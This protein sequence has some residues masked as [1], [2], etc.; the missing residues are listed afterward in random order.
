[1]HDAQWATLKSLHDNDTLP[2]FWIFSGDKGCGKSYFAQ[3]WI[4]YWVRCHDIGCDPR[5]CIVQ[6]DKEIVIDDIV[7]LRRFLSAKHEGK[8]F[9]LIDNANQMNRFVQNALLKIFE[10]NYEDT[11]IILI[12]HHMGGLLPTLISRFHQLNFSLH[13][14]DIEE[15]LH[16]LIPYAGL[17]RYYLEK[18]AA[19]GGL[20]WVYQFKNLIDEKYVR[21]EWVKKYAQHAQDVMYFLGQIVYQQALISPSHK[22]LTTFERINGF[23]IDIPNTHLRDEDVLRTGIKLAMI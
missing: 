9:V 22:N 16:P 15:A 3:K 7:K 6:S 5:V 20:E 1:M 21:E 23:L 12:V 10:T 19:L 2:S 13:P 14:E 18:L 4:R 8:R 17:S 11:L